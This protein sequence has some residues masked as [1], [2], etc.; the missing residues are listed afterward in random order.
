MTPKELQIVERE[1]ASIYRMW[2]ACGLKEA[3]RGIPKGTLCDSCLSSIAM[4]MSRIKAK[5]KP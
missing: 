2:H 1:V 4:H 5:V 3:E